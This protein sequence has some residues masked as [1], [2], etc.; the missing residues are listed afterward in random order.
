MAQIYKKHIFDNIHGYIHLNRCEDRIMKTAYFQRLRWIRQLGFSFYIFPGATHTRFSHVLGVLHV[1]H[2]ILKSIEKAVPDEKL[3][4]PD[5]NDGATNF[6]KTMRLAAMLHD[7]GTFPF[8]HTVEL[9]YINHWKK[10]KARGVKKLF[11]A[12]HETLGAHI[13]LNTDF[14]GGITR[15][16]KE[17]G[18]DP[19]EL[20]KVISGQSSNLLANQLMHSDIDA[21]R[22]DYLLRDSLHTG[23]KFGTY[24]ID[25]LIR[26]LTTFK[27]GNQEALAVKDEAISFVDYFLFCR[28]SWYSQIIDDGTGYKFDLIAAKINEYFLENGQTHS[29]E[30]L[31]KNVS[32]DPNQYFT[33]NDNY[34]FARIQE[35]IAG[36]VTHPMIRELTEML[37]YRS[38]PKQI[39]IPPAE[40]TLV[41][42]EDHRNEL[43]KQVTEAAQ[44]LESEIKLIDPN[45]WMIFDIPQKDVMFTKSL[46]T[47]RKDSRGT[48]PL[49]ARDPVKVLTRHGEPKLLI[50]VSNAL[51]KI[52]SQYRNFIPRIYVSPKTYEALKRKGVLDKM[53]ARYID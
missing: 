3:F 53:L 26:N 9:G 19:L 21:D 7:I 23:V 40:P 6:H 31:M 49:L 32:Q 17:E 51:M 37:A 47:I 5:V 4:D 36:P 46:D 12:N 24:D 44:W 42:S 22:M 41:E 16:L 30:N 45:A 43:I 2:R 27:V 11:D 13:I 52:L 34:F 39:K 1:M 29:F 48:D 33:F 14:E 18:I 20:S 15:I 38:P 28:Y 50:E 8:S 35:F 25:Q 10:Q